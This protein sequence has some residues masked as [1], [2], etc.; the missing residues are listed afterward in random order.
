MNKLQVVDLVQAVDHTVVTYPQKLFSISHLSITF[1][2]STHP[3]PL[4]KAK[5]D[6]KRAA[7]EK[8]ADEADPSLTAPRGFYFNIMK[9]Q[10]LKCLNRMRCS[11]FDVSCVLTGANAVQKCGE[12]CGDPNDPERLAN[13]TCLVGQNGEAYCVEK[14]AIRAIIPYDRGPLSGEN[15]E[16]MQDGFLD[17]G[18]M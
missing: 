1:T 17:V 13:D 11:Q 2:M 9:N 8:S 10:W 5:A 6:E 3:H 14:E 4:Q 18:T 15:G 12:G 16:K 7:A